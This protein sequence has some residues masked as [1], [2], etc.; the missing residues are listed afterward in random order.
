MG[1]IL[2]EVTFL[3]EI[4]KWCFLVKDYKFWDWMISI[5][6]VMPQ[7]LQLLLMIEMMKNEP[8]KC[9]MKILSNDKNYY[10]LKRLIIK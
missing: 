6:S 10:V 8:V 5:V 4:I 7:I 9:M 1:R 2:S 3:D